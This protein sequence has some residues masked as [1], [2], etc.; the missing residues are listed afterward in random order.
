M[1]ST[2]VLRFARYAYPPNQLGYC[3]PDDNRVLLEYVAAGTADGGLLD[4]ARR[5]EGA[6]PYLCLIAHAN[7]IAD[8]FDERV[9]EA[10]WL[11][12]S[13]LSGVTGP[14]FMASLTE[15]FGPRL[16]AQELRWLEP[17]VA[18]GARPHHNFHV[19][20]MYSRLGL[21]RDERATRA[22]E[23]MDRCRISWAT[24][25][26]VETERLLVNRPPLLYLDGRLTLGPATPL[27][28]T[29]TTGGLGLISEV[30]PAD[31]VAVHWDWACERLDER[32]LRSLAAATRRC[33][34]L[35]NQTI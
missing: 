16:G 2:G 29:W 21:M 6:Y 18:T 9:V 22:L 34:N 17:K 26:K 13:L 35:A 32:G 28:V 19:F 8:A 33:L 12:N 31:R 7:G 14:T 3:G 10:Y 27:W 11:G 24:V 30:K 20:D 5:F 15:R 4:L 1:T 25:V 23:V